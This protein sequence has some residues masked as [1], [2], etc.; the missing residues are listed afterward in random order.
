[1]KTRYKSKRKTTKRKRKGSSIYDKPRVGKYIFILILFAL[2]IIYLYHIIPDSI[3]IKFNVDDVKKEE[4]K[5]IVKEVIEEE[6]QLEEKQAIIEEVSEATKKETEEVQITSRGGSSSRNTTSDNK[7]TGYRITSYHPGDGCAS[8]TKTGSGKSIN[9][10]STMKIGNKNVYTYNGKIVVACATKELFNTG[11][12]V[13]GSQKTQNK[14]YFKYYQEFTLVID[15]VNYPA[16]CLDS[17]GAAMWEG[18]Y[19]IDIFVPSSSDII[20]RSNVT[21]YL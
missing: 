15:G 3:E 2:A 19:R 1:M 6:K 7:L 13:N 20:N 10:F 9:D 5:Q 14:Y 8:G 11:Y 21:A 17:C 16:I 4:I 18:E 12:S